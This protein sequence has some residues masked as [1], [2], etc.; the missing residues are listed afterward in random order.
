MLMAAAATVT[1][2]MVRIL[3]NPSSGNNP[4][5]THDKRRVSSRSDFRVVKR[6]EKVAHSQRLSVVRRSVPARTSE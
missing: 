4:A 5:P 6:R 2:Y 3:R 1:L